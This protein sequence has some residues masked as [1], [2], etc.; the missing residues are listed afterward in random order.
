MFI[1][2]THVFKDKRVTFPW[3]ITS[4]V[5]GFYSEPRDTLDFVFI[6]S[7]QMFTS[8]APAVLWSEY[9][10]T[11]YDFGANEQPFWL[12]YAFIKECVKTQKPKAVVLDVRYCFFENEYATEGVTRVNLDDLKWSRDK[13]RAVRNSTAPDQSITY[14]IEFM[15]YHSNWKSLSRTHF[16]RVTGTHDPYRGY[17][18]QLHARDYPELNQAFIESS[19]ARPL[20]GRNEKTLMDIIKLSKNEGFTLLLIKI[21][22]SI[23]D[24][25]PLYNRVAQIA[26]ENGVDYIDYNKIMSGEN[27]MNIINA[28]KFSSLLGADLVARYEVTDKRGDPAYSRWEDDSRYFYQQKQKHLAMHEKDIIKYLGYIDNPNYVVLIAARDEA[29]NQIASVADQWRA[30]GFNVGLEGRYRESFIGVISGG[31]VIHETVSAQAL[32]FEGSIGETAYK[33]VSQGYSVGN[34]ASI[35]LD[36]KE[37][38][39]NR[40]GLNFV[41]YDVL[42]REV[43]DKVAFDTFSALECYR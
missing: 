12:S 21:P 18:P 11:S 38:A 15:K 33:V 32:S 25:Q 34:K 29:S 35:I 7:S 20:A 39:L 19:E 9:G 8:I 1:G 26:A 23:L 30:L 10:I 2:M 3:N 14:M 22:D 24:A 43:V 37:L 40:R 42:L 17:T 6:G 41:V 5:N 16:L 4:K 36:G 13:V 27:H 28:E 31:E